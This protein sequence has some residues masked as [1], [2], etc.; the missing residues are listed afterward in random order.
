MSIPQKT[1]AVIEWASRNLNNDLQ[2][3]YPGL[4]A[5]FSNGV[6][7]M[8]H[9]SGGRSAAAMLQNGCGRVTSL[10]LMDPVDGMS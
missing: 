10:I 2:K 3:I 8:G 5:D 6:S 7:I 4:S 9:S 1:A